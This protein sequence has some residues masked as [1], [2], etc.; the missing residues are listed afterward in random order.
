MTHNVS[1]IIPTWNGK[2]L[3]ERYL[4]SVKAAV[5]AYPGEAEVVVVDDGSTDD[6]MAFLETQGVTAVRRDRNGG[7][8]RAVSTGV[9]ASSGDVLIFLN[10]DVEVDPRFIAPLVHHFSDP[11]V[12]QVTSLGLLED[13]N[14]VGEGHKSGQFKR[15]LLKFLRKGPRTLSEFRKAYPRAVPTL[16]A[17]GGHSALCRRRFLELGGFDPLYEPFYWEDVDLAYCAQKR[18]WKVLLEPASLVFHGRGGTIGKAF[19]KKSSE[20]IKKRNRLIFTWKNITEPGLFLRRHLIPFVLRVLFGWIILDLSFYG[21]FFAA[22]KRLP[23]IAGARARERAS[24]RVCDS[25]IFCRARK[26]GY[27]DA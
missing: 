4:P 22:L 11:A 21:P 2:E 27:D 16:F 20:A 26:H 18:G 9:T 6:T 8:A 15:G 7:Y 12:F 10:N 3:L 25:D 17:S 5:S 24:Q 13:K 23:R 19:R 14:T 1:I